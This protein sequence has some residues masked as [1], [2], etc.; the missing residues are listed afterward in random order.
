MGV[1]ALPWLLHWA[2][3]TLFSFIQLIQM[4]SFCHTHSWQHPEITLDQLL[5]CPLTQASWRLTKSPELPLAS[6][7]TLALTDQSISQCI[8]KLSEPYSGVVHPSQPCLFPLL[9]VACSA[10]PVPETENG[11]S[12]HLVIYVFMCSMIIYRVN[13]V[14]R[15]LG[16]AWETVIGMTPALT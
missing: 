7:R 13:T 12:P 11:F 10:S 5:G 8:E 3:A 15:S 6:A 9:H 2:W 14:C 16:W 1:S 4:V